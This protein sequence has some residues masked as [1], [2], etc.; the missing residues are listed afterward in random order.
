MNGAD[1]EADTA[2]DTLFL[3]DHM[4]L[5]LFTGNHAEYRTYRDTCGA[6]VAFGIDIGL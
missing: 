1:I 4:A 2:T 3:V 5:V 6:A